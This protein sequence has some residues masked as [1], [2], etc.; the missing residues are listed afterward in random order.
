M[1][2][3]G[4]IPYVVGQWVRGER[5]YGREAVL[6]EVL[7][8]QR[9]SLWVLGTRRIGKTSL[10]KQLEYRASAE[11]SE[12]VPLFWDFQGADEP[13]E[14]HLS[15]H[16]A[17]LDAEERL[18]VLGVDPQRMDAE[19]L[20]GS[21][22]MLRRHLR[23][24][25]RRLLLLCDE[26]E[27]LIK[28]SAQDPALLRK[29]RRTL[30]SGSEVRSVLT[31]TIRL[32]ALAEERGDT[33]PFLHGFAPPIYLSTMTNDEARSLL[34]QDQQTE[35]VRPALDEEAV[36]A[37]AG[38]C[39]NHPYLLQLL[40]KRYLEMG[41]VDEAIQQVASDEIVS[42]FFAVDFEMLSPVEQQILR[43]LGEASAVS[44]GSLEE[45]LD[46]TSDQVGGG[47]LRLEGLGFLKR[48]AERQLELTN[49][50]FREWIRRV[51]PRARDLHGAVSEPLPFSERV[52]EILSTIEGTVG[53]EDP[54]TPQELLDEVYEDLRRLA[55]RYMSRERASHTLQP[56]AL[57]HEA[58]MK[59]AEQS[60]VEWQGKT[61]FFAVGAQAMRR[62]LIDHAR[63]R[64]RN[65]RGGDWLRVSFAEEIFAGGKR[66]LNDEEL[67]DLDRAIQD[68][69]EI[70]GRQARVVELRFFGGLTVEEVAEALKVSKRTADGDWAKARDWLKQRLSR[71]K[72]PS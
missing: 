64:Q 36:R 22:S 28:L 32:W 16:D 12:F 67:I 1:S 24:K 43:T 25:G 4:S 41:D 2:T 48:N 53:A 23:A 19:D 3:V 30:Q 44:R 49:R 56:T 42:Y 13:R 45:R 27:E 72:E 10:L 71:G 46:L 14:L 29:L 51:A 6:S 58:Y 37:I 18:K 34:C 52:T 62:V 11:T 50:F 65:K 47:I 69:A 33:S 7:S 68:L 57:V 59:L 55:R 26:V 15:F 54:A 38:A 70:D 60:R 40:G 17:L 20:F 61:H 66:G 9:E 8:G 39:G 35:A 21:I 63:G 31:S 5:F